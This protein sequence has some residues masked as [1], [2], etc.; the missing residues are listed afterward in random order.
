VLFE[1]ASSRVRDF[2][3]RLLLKAYLSHT[4]PTVLS[5]EMLSLGPVRL[6]WD[7][8]KNSPFLNRTSPLILATILLVASI[9][10]YLLIPETTG[11]T[12]LLGSDIPKSIM[13]LQGQDPYST[14]P[15]SAPYPP[16]LL[17]TVAGIIRISS[18]NL[19]QNPAAIN[20]IDQNVRIGGIFAG[21]LVSTIIYIALRRRGRTGLE[22]LIPATLFVTLPAISTAPLY[23][24]RSDIF[25]YPILAL[26][27][28]LLTLGHRYAGTTL[29]A[30]SAIYKLHPILAVPSILIWLT[31]RYGV[32]Q[33]LPILLTTTT[34]IGVGLILPFEIPGYAQAVLGFNL[35]NAGTGTNTFSILNLLYG[36][37]PTFGLT[38]PATVANQVWIS[39]TMAL[40]TVTIG[41]V[42]RNADSIDPVQIVLLGLAGWL[43]PLKMLFTGYMVWAFIPLFMIGRLRTAVLLSGVLQAADT[44][45]YWSSFPA[46]S[47]IAGMGS[48]YGFFGTSL[49]YCLISVLALKTV[50][51]AR[52]IGSR[53]HTMAVSRL[54]VV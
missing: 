48:V 39:A 28:L 17:L 22:A 9:R 23:W 3:Y 29:L 16:L 40:L 14:A 49:V 5:P 54:G 41:F 38:T 27:L 4:V 11:G 34:I 15:W 50:L 1:E 52:N 8:A 51:G 7:R 42:W 30:I 46:N 24:F 45:A 10:I 18:G 47:P 2:P 37:F 35:A 13:L 26:S 53:S 31:K 12:D 44:M 20:V 36:I 33:T 6:A 43:L 25:G 32:R 19:F 21:A